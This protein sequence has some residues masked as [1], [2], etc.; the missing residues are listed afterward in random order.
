M[1]L[2]NGLDADKF[3]VFHFRRLGQLYSEELFMSKRLWAFDAT[4]DRVN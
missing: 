2:Q 1:A 3:K 4:Y